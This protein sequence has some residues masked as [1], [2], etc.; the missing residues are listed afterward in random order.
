MHWFDGN[1][2]VLPLRHEHKGT[3][4]LA[5]RLD[6]LVQHLIKTAWVPR[7]IKVACAAFNGTA[8]ADVQGQQHMLAGLERAVS[9]LAAVAGGARVRTGT[10]GQYCTIV[11]AG[12]SIPQAAQ[13]DA[14]H[15]HSAAAGLGGAPVAEARVFTRE[16]LLR[17][18]GTDPGRPIY[19]AVMGEVYDVTK[20]AA[21]YAKGRGGGYSVFA[22]T[23]ASRAFATGEFE[24]AQRPPGSPPMHDVLDLS[25]EQLLQI[26]EWK[27]MYTKGGDNNAYF[28]VGYL[29]MQDGYYD[30]H[31]QPTRK[32]EVATSMFKAA[33][34]ADE[35]RRALK[36]LYPECLKRYKAS[37]GGKVW[38]ADEA[39]VP[40]KGQL[41]WDAYSR[42]ACYAPQFAAR[43]AGKLAVYSGC[44]PEADACKV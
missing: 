15:A 40:R 28:F 29:H 16:E 43:Q 9:D 31:G 25:P 19:L 8:A 12:S 3:R 17:F 5:A 1:S 37:E 13:E 33:L 39:L 2:A 7:A 4:G 24:P 11:A 22:G 21:H 10:L 30:A 23:D 41:Q 38:C 34:D 18:D 36:G 42:C 27:Q 44:D 32:A 20:G 6:A 26:L 14:D 35:R